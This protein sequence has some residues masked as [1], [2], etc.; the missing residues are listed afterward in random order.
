MVFGFTLYLIPISRTEGSLSPAFNSLL[1]IC[2][3]I[4]STNCKYIGFEALNSSIVYTSTLLS[5]IHELR[6]YNPMII[7]KLYIYSP[8]Y[9][10]ID[11][12][13][14]AENSKWISILPHWVNTIYS[15]VLSNKAAIHPDRNTMPI[16]TNKLQ[17]P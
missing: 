14:K 4:R 17:R 1:T 6:T 7:I 8:A 15:L 2:R 3:L 13:V 11:S 5:I 9:T 12:I 16:T 10:G